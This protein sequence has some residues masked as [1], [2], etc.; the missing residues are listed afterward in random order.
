MELRNAKE[1]HPNQDHEAALH[2]QVARTAAEEHGHVKYA[3]A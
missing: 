1:L 2:Q 3:M